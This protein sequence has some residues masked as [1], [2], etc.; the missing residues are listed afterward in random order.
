MKRRKVRLMLRWMG[1]WRDLEV[2][3]LAK[4]IISLLALPIP[5]VLVVLLPM[6]VLGKAVAHL[7]P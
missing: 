3:V 6:L 5:V 2:Q 1:T 4:V 7:R